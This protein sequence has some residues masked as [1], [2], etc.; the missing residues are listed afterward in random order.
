MAKPFGYE[1][2][3]VKYIV[4]SV[5]F[6]TI[7]MYIFGG[8]VMSFFEAVTHTIGDGFVSG[9]AYYFLTKYLPPTSVSQVVVQIVMGA[10]VAGI[11]WY[12]KTPRQTSRGTS[13]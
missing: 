2:G 11:L 13:W 8:G 1:I 4:M 5:F 7:P 3:A 12:V 10:I 9:M 6:N